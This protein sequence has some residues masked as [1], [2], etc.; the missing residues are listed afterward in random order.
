MRLHRG[1][2]L[3]L[4]AAI[5]RGATAQAFGQTERPLVELVVRAETPLRVALD[6]RVRLKRVGQTVTG[7]LT[8]AIYSYDRVVVPAGT[9]AWGRVTKLEKVSGGARFR[10][11][12]G[13]DFTPLRRASLEFDTLV[14]EDCSEIPIQT[15]VRSAIAGLVLKVKDQPTKGIAGRAAEEVARKA[16]ETLSSVKKPGRMRRLKDAL[17]G[18]LPYHPQY[19]RA[20]TVFTAVLLS[21]L[22]FG[23]VEATEV[24][25]PG[26]APPPET[27]LHARMLTPLDS[28]RT[29]RGTAIRAV[30]TEPVFSDDR[31]LIL[32]EG[33]VLAGEVTFVRPA[34]W[35]HRNGQLRFLFETVQA[36]E[37]SLETMRASLYSVQVGKD[38]RLAVDEEGG[39]TMTNSN[40]RFVGPAL[41]GLAFGITMHRHL[42]YDTDG[43]GPETAYGTGTS[44]GAGGFFGFGLLGAG[45]TQFS[46]PVTVGLGVV[47]LV[48]TAFTSIARRGR[49]V[50]F[51]AH[52]RI[53]VQ[54]GPAP[55]PAE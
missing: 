41:A 24:A 23:A 28:A 27:V 25:P 38:E 6:E 29:P 31:R 3:L 9:K 22:S 36:P 40:K 43:L 32:P 26:M 16:H 13:G 2:V 21:P 4:A 7:T 20:G 35:F 5:S 55:E 18:R 46:R 54:L 33:A 12:L 15:E 34:A 52:T 37:E 39:T 17:I 49:N 48:R 30:V 19:L 50:S 51:P 1:I 11:I 47:G 53:E 42:D 14:L 45:L 44:A 8:E 10:A